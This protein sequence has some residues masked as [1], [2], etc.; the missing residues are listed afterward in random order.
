IDREIA[1]LKSSGMAELLRRPGS[2]YAELAAMDASRRPVPESVGEEVE[3]ELKYEGYIAQQERAAARHREAWDD[4]RI[5]EE[6]SFWRIRGLSAEAAEKLERYRPLT[7]GQA[8]RIPGVTPAALSL[9]LVHLRRGRGSSALSD[10][11]AG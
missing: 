3:T 6:L 7:V 1:R 9:L 5:P 2:T 4:W 8:K 10:A 11:D